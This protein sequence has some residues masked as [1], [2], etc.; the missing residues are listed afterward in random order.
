M[1]SPTES[2]TGEMVNTY[3]GIANV[4]AKEKISILAK[5]L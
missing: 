3:V 5:E 1:G 2:K 4:R